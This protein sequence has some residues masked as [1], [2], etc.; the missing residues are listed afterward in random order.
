VEGGEGGEREGAGGECPR[1]RVPTCERVVSVHTYMHCGCIIH[2]HACMCVC[3][4]VCMY[5]CVFKCVWG[6]GGGV[7]GMFVCVFVH[8]PAPHPYLIAQQR[9]KLDTQLLNHNGSS[10]GD[11]KAEPTVKRY[12]SIRVINHQLA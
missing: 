10:R 5:V 6:G 4:C 9:L 3:V 7:G 12:G 2:L 8:K 1:K 11:P